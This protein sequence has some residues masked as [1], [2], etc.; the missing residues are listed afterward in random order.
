ML[1]AALTLPLTAATV[2]VPPALPD[3]QGCQELPERRLRAVG[4]EARIFRWT[5]CA[6][7]DVSFR[8][9]L[10]APSGGEF[11][12]YVQVRQVDDVDRT[13]RLLARLRIRST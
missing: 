13:D 8:E 9:V 6:G 4:L 3:H 2:L 12:V 1:R 11:G 5:H 7:G 10:L